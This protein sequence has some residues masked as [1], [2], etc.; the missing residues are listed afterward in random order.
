MIDRICRATEIEELIAS[1]H[2]GDVCVLDSD[3]YYLS[4]RI[5]IKDKTNIVI[6]GNG[7]TFVTHYVNSESYE[8]S[9][10]AVL[11]ENCTGVTLKNL[12]FDTDT[13]TNISATVEEVCNES[14]ALVI[15]VDDA[16]DINGKEVLMAF[17]SVDSDGSF[18]YGLAYYSRHPDPNVITLIQD[19]ILCFATYSGAKNEYLGNN[20]F[21]VYFGS[22][23][24]LKKAYVGMRLCIRHTMYGPSTITIRNSDKTVLQDITMYSVAGFG[25]MVLSRCEDLTIDGLRMPLV[26]GGNSYMSC[27]CDGV[28]ITGLVGRFEMKNC[29][30]DG[31]GDDALNIHATAG[32]VTGINHKSSSIKCNYCK[33]TDD[34]ILPDNWCR[35]GDLIRFYDPDTLKVCATAKVLSFSD[36]NLLYE[37]LVGHVDVG[38]MMQN[39]AFTPKCDISNCIVRNT[40]ARGFLLQTENV[41]ISDCEFFGMSHNAIKAA[42]AFI[43]W[44]EVGPSHNLKIINNTI[45]KCG[46][47]SDRIAGI[48][49]Q[50]SHDGNDENIFG[51]HS[52]IHIADNRIEASKGACIA[53]SSADNVVIR[54]NTFVSQFVRQTDPVKTVAC[55]NVVVANNIEVDV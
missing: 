2:S 25:V 8:S 27:N 52:N 50:T 31:L 54:D 1:T 10:D 37:E 44:Y 45:V 22:E 19:E 53:V 17:N 40:R 21:L 42:P 46:F 29:F 32:T 41:K 28:H 38:F 5:V 4:R 36:G 3:R 14:S 35:K 15:K 34:G 51:L 16:F 20:R 30:F 26:K 49:V 13:P 12:K 48:A 47:I 39:T 43:K 18:D 6:D 33:K 9:V 7:A 11:L 23:N 24:A 55:T